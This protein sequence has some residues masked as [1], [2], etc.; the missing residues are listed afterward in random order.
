MGFQGGEYEDGAT[1]ATE[2]V[3]NL[4][5]GQYVWLEI[6]GDEEDRFGRLRRYVWLTYPENP[7]YENT[8]RQYMINAKLLEQG[9]AELAIFGTPK[10]EELFRRLSN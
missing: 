7:N 8:I 1:E 3:R 10:H 5:E 2:F 6:D 9:F 4:I